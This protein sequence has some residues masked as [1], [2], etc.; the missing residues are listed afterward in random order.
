MIPLTRSVQNNEAELVSLRTLVSERAAQDKEV[1]DK[2]A[3]YNAKLRLEY[4]DYYN[5]VHSIKYFS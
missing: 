2:I 4:Q 3:V 1:A 5:I